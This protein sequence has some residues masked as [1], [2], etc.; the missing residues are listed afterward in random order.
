MSEPHILK[1]RRRRRRVPHPGR[2]S[3]PSGSGAPAQE[4]TIPATLSGT[5][6]GLLALA[7]VKL[8]QVEAFRPGAIVLL[9][10]AVDEL[11]AEFNGRTPPTPGA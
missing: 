9:E 4:P 7:M 3:A 6:S 8:V 11:L 5:L 2:P 1:F 10:Q